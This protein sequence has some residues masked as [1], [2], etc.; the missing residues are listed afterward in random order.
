[1]RHLHA[2][3]FHNS[4]QVTTHG[5]RALSFFLED[6]HVGITLPV[7]RAWQRHLTRSVPAGQRAMH[8]VW[9]GTHRPHNTT[10]AIARA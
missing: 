6:E 1:M 3:C 8:T 2:Q 4:H 9:A 10:Y 5:G 7:L